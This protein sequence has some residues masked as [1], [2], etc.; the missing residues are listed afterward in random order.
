MRPQPGQGQVPSSAGAFDKTVVSNGV[1]NHYYKNGYLTVQPS[2]QASWYGYRLGVVSISASAQPLNDPV[3]LPDPDGNDSIQTAENLSL[4]SGGADLGDGVNSNQVGIG[5]ILSSIGGKDLNDF[6]KFSIDSLKLVNFYLSQSGT[7]AQWWLIQDRNGNGQVD[8]G[9]AIKTGTITTKPLDLD[10]ILGAGDYYLQVGSLSSD[11]TSVYAVNVAARALENQVIA[12]YNSDYYL[13]QNGQLR[14]IPNQETLTEMGIAANTVKTFSNQ[15]LTLIPYGDDLPSRKNG[16]VFGDLSGRIYLMESGKRRLVPDWDTLR[17]I[18]INVTYFPMFPESDIKDI[19]LGDPYAPPIPQ[20]QKDIDNT[21]QYTRNLLGNPTGSYWQAG[22][23]PNGT[24]GYGQNYDNGTIYW[25]AQ[26][27][28]IALW[29]AFKDTYNQNGGSSGWLG[30][31][32]QGERPWESGQRIDFE[33]GYIYWTAQSGAKAYRPNESPSLDKTVG[34]DGT[35]THQTY[36]NTFNNNGGL[37][38]LGSATGNVHP[39]GTANGYIQEF[40]GGSEGS[41][42]I[43]KSGANDYSYWVGSFFWDAYVKTGGVTGILGYPISDRYEF[44]GGWKQDFQGGSLST[45]LPLTPTPNSG[46]NTSPQ[47]PQILSRLIESGTGKLITATNFRSSPWA[48][49]SNSNLMQ[50]GISAGTTFTLLENVTTNDPTYP[51]WY[52][53]RLNNGDVGYFWANNVEKLAS[54]S[55]DSKPILNFNSGGIS[56]GNWTFLSQGNKAQQ[57]E[58]IKQ[59]I[60]NLGNQINAIEASK[61]TYGSQISEKEKAVKDKKDQ[62]N[63]LSW[64]NSWNP[65]DWLKAGQ[66]TIEAGLIE[67][68]TLPQLRAQYSATITRLNQLKQ[69]LDLSRQELKKLNPLPTTAAEANKYFKYQFPPG[70]TSYNDCGPSSLAMVISLLG[71]EKPNMTVL[72]SINEANSLM[73]RTSKSNSNTDQIKT[74]IEAI[75]A[76][77]DFMNGWKNLDS[78]LENGKPVICWGDITRKWYDLFKNKFNNVHNVNPDGVIPHVIAI[79]GKTSNGK[80]IVGDPAFIGKEMVEMEKDDLSIFFNAQNTPNSNKGNPRGYAVAWQ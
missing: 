23:S 68:G 55:G 2:G 63:K 18:G 70:W 5:Y 56:T 60:L 46:T 53:V 76:R 65:L 22:S 8:P 45:T 59:K 43:M 40:S 41:G 48:D 21:Y 77:A 34:Y 39:T 51:N 26:S 67:Y 29:Y 14:L 62:A 32:T 58:Q 35:N 30:F 33:G 42:A 6:Y 38:A 61:A 13:V 49:P 28:A 19:K 66:L 54:S 7:A 79:L 75:G 9:E 37:S 44:N 16:D 72:Q 25:T 52:R 3:P 12:S 15:D 64:P 20:W 10:V 80:Y 74:G 78:S 69:E 73:G 57:I 36:V 1:V 71:I 4:V 11:A 17:A 24:Q 47:A 31:P 27:G 50:Q